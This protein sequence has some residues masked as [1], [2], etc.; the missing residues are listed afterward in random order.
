M[1]WFHGH[2]ST[3][4]PVIPAVIIQAVSGQALD[5]YRLDDGLFPELNDTTVRI[6]T[7]RRAIL[8]CVLIP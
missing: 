7:E 3:V 8:P 1:A 4:N 5:H 2:I 6:L